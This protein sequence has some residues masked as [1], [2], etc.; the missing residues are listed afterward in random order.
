MAFRKSGSSSV[1]KAL[2]L[3]ALLAALSTVA[4]GQARPI[5][6]ISYDPAVS[7][8]DSVYTDY[9][10]STDMTFG[11]DT[12]SVDSVSTLWGTTNYTNV[13]PNTAQIYLRRSTAFTSSTTTLLMQA[14]GTDS[15]YTSTPSD[16]S[17]TLLSGNMYVGL[18]NPFYNGEGQ[19]NVERIDVYFGAAHVVQASDVIILFDLGSST[20]DRF[21]VAPISG[22]N[23]NAPTAYASVGV[24]VFSSSLTNP[25]TT[26][27][28]MATADYYSATYNTTG[29]LG[30]TADSLTLVEDVNL[31][32]VVIRLTDLGL[33]VGS[34]I[35]GVSLMGG[36]V[37]PGQTTDLLLYNN[38][39]IFPTTSGSQYAGVDFAGFG[40]ILA[41]PVPEPS[42][43]G[44]IL[45]G[46][47][48][49][50]LAWRRRRKVAVA[51]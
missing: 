49:G 33:A 36:D 45:S 47:V 31:T 15:V 4:L 25:I 24:P 20:G 1:S 19:A 9:S 34:T 43:Y 46:G 41:S 48:L 37:N 16:L 18:S 13:L 7:G 2:G 29:S 28:G 42:T 44:A 21:R 11:N 3:G 26:P 22:W 27:D 30:G 50:F 5:T 14:N 38:Q 23:N 35:Y 12:I 17:S 6:G 39:Y 40:N 10:G 32:G 8:V 51:V